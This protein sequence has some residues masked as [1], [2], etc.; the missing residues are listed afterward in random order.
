MASKIQKSKDAYI[1]DNIDC[2]LYRISA[3]SDSHRRLL[4]HI[5][6]YSILALYVGR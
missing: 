2:L 3:C 4:Y 1:D 5:Y 6:K